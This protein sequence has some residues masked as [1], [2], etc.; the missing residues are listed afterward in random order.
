MPATPSNAYWLPYSSNR[1]FHK[2][3][4]MVTGAEG[5]FLHDDKGRKIFDS[6]SG[7]WCCGYGHGRQEIA[8]A[9]AAQLTH[10][11]LY[12]SPSPRDS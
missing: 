5:A 11:L 9:V 2:S 3:P 7:L 12:T 4:R 6:L 1:A 8:D 10:C